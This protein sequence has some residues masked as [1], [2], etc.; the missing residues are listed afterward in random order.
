ML[1]AQPHTAEW[2]SSKLHYHNL[3]GKKWVHDML[4]SHQFLFLLWLWAFIQGFVGLTA[5]LNNKSPKDDATEDHVVK[6]AFKNISF[7][8]D[9]PCVDFIEQL[10]HHKGVEDNGVVLRGRRVKRGVTSTVNVEYLF[11]WEMSRKQNIVTDVW[12]MLL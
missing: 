9:L 12:F 10:H 8:V 1:N 7:S 6:N 4:R 2:L 11:T 5:Y 3:S